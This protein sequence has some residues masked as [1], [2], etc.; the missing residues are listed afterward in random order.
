VT[1]DR[2]R[3]E[4]TILALTAARGAGRSI[5]PAD[6]AQALAREWR[7]LLG[8]VRQAAARLAQAGRIDILRK[9]KPVDPAAMKGVIR[10]R[11][12]GD[13]VP[14]D[15]HAQVGDDAGE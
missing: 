8:P 6:A 14:P 9:G 3:I 11:I 7:P 1:I 13:G 2:T 15:D 4:A 10:L 5:A 12:R